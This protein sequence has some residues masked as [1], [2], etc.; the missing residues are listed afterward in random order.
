MGVEAKIE[1]GLLKVGRGEPGD[2]VASD[3]DDGFTGVGLLARVIF[4]LKSEGN[5]KVDLVKENSNLYLDDG[6]GTKMELDYRGGMY[7]S[8]GEIG[9]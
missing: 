6:L 4:R 8:L 9:N 3:S 1:D 7:S 5:A 2:G